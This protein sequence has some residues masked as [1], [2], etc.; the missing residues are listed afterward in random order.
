MTPNIEIMVRREFVHILDEV[1]E[2]L[3][4]IDRRLWGS[5]PAFPCMWV[6]LTEN[7]HPGNDRE[8]YVI[9]RLTGW[10]CAN[11]GDLTARTI[12]GIERK[13]TTLYVTDLGREL[14]TAIADY[15]ANK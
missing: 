3:D 14:I 13:V 11:W 7:P 6:K 2:I 15:K 10:K 5:C 12:D 4:Q 8:E 1:S 9:D